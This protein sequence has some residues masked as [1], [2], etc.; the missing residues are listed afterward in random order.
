M[1]RSDFLPFALPDLDETEISEVNE[2]IRSGWLTTGAKTRQFEQEFAAY[3]GVK[4]AVAVNSATAAMH[5]ALE[6]IG[7]QR[8]DE[9]ITSPLTF[10]A[11]A[12][13][14]RYFDARPVFVDVDPDSLNLDPRQVERAVTSRT[15]ALLPVHLAGLAVD[16]DAM[17][18]IASHY[19]IA[20]IEDAAHALPTR[21]H[22]CLIGAGR[23]GAAPNRQS[24]ITCFSFYA[25]KTL[26]T[27]EGGMLTTDDDII[28]ERC[29]IMSL[30]GI[31]R[32][33]WKRYT[34]DGSW[35]YEIIA[36]GFKYNLTD[37][38]AAMGLAQLRKVNRMW[39]RR[40]EIARRYSQAF[41]VL[42][43]LEVPV[44][45]P[46]GDQH[47]W[48][49]YILRLNLDALAIDRAEF[50]AQLKSRNIGASVHF[51]PLH[52]HPYYRET[53]GYR[54]EDFPIA[55]QQY[56]RLI[57]LP[58]Y[59]KMTDQDIQDVIDAILEIVA[60]YRC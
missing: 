2:T 24:P 36:P 7:L 12:E 41:G 14:I 16:R 34:A 17:L 59:S 4:H 21:Q 8:D 10:A 9:V 26:T 22:G 51:I 45:A 53:Y 11:T 43:E 33:A 52:L 50:I 27:G 3:V 29:R 55:Y 15:R 60:R 49:L 6:A 58:I 31:S 40:S 18:E 35:Y 32:D 20:V 25:T 1:S 46:K 38:A 37:M 56:R 54:P 48:H 57:S 5:L 47:A 19:D 13:V 39:Q 23:P 28:A 30:H 44:D 42:P